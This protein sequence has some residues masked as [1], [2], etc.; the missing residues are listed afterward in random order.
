MPKLPNAVLVTAG[1]QRLGFHIAQASLAM[2]F[3]VVLHYRTSDRRARQWL[4]RHPEYCDRVHF[5]QQDLTAEPHTVIESAMRLPCKLTGLVNNASVFT[6]GNLFATE[7]L[8][9]MLEIHFFTPAALGASFARRVRHGWIINMT[10][11]LSHHPNLSWQNY[12]LS[13]MFLEEL[14]RQQALLFAPECRVNAIAPGAVLPPRQGSK[15]EFKALADHIPLKKTS[16]VAA[17]ADAFHFLVSNTSCTG[18]IVNID[19]GWNLTA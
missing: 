2:G 18:Q 1:T 19:G 13:K 12:R 8:R 11:A 4:L 6:K 3:A 5:L 16:S 14:T 9:S 7:H 15:T 10:D 17:L